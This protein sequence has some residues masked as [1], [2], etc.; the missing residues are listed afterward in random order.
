MDDGRELHKVGT[1]SDGEYGAQLTED[2]ERCHLQLRGTF[3]DTVLQKWQ[4]LGPTSGLRKNRNGGLR[5]L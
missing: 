1:K 4:K 2:A 3:S 5:G